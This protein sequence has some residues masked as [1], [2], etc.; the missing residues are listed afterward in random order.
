MKI[1]EFDSAPAFVF[2][3][4]NAGNGPGQFYE[5]RLPVHIARVDRLPEGMSVLVATADLQGR[6]PFEQAS[7]GS[8]RL[9]GEVLPQ[10]L[11][12]EVLPTL[13]LNQ[14]G[15]I[16]ALLAGDFYTVPTLDRRGGTGDVTGV[17]RAFA[18]C[19]DW[20][21]GIFGNHD[22]FDGR[23][24]GRPRTSE[25]IHYLDG[26]WA[27]ICGMRI[28]GLGGVV[29]KRRTPNCRTEVEYLSAV[30]YLLRDSP[31]VLL[32]HDGPDGVEPGQRG[33]P[34]VRELLLNSGMGLVI[35]GHAHW[36]V[37]LAE[38]E[39]G[40]QVLNVDARVVILTA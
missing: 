18:D 23:V 34:L 16:G 29:G 26:R 2:P 14:P 8:L 35:R 19:F 7:G 38:F 32:L 11:V 13:Q 37:P 25:R 20:V 31:D 36:D 39:S 33:L 21:A 40:L 27:D 24:T 12:D 1:V 3:Y 22:R 15:Q 5:D 30:Q 4:L 6:E 10:R 17:W 9:L 28:A